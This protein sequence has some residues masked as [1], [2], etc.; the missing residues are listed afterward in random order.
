MLWGDEVR[1]TDGIPTG[2][3]QPAKA[4]VDQ[5]VALIEA[6]AT[7]WDPTAYKDEYR[8]RLEDVIDRKRK[9]KKISA[10][11]PEKAPSPVPDLMAALEKS[12]ADAQG[13]GGKSAKTKPAGKQPDELASL[14][15]DELYER[16]QEED[17]PGRSS[18]SKDELVDAL[19]G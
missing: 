19:S 14:S 4:E 1:S 10:P 6:L 3:K 9:G 17:I 11:K 16:A 15:R 7:E 18:M 2:G 5:A 12:L 13:G 8:A